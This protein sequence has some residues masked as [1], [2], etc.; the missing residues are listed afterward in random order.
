VGLTISAYSLNSAVTLLIAFAIASFGTNACPAIIFS[1]APSHL[2]KAAMPAG[3]AFVSMIANIGGA[4]NQ[5]LF[6]YLKGATAGPSTGL[7]LIA[8]F[9]LAGAILSGVMLKRQG[10]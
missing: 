4:F 8:G 3:I 10:G 6:G 7:L 5:P 2:S 1:T 9:A